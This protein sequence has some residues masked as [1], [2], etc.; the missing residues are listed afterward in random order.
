MKKLML[1]CGSK[2]AERSQVEEARTPDGTSTWTPISH[3]KL[4][5]EIEGSLEKYG[6]RVDSEAYG[7]SEG[8][9]RMFGILSISNCQKTKDYSY[10]LGVR[11][12]HD[13]RF[14]AG[15]CIGSQVFVCDNLAFSSEITINRKHTKH[16][17]R[18]LPDMVFKAVGRLSDR[19]NDQDSRIE[20]YK[21]KRITSVRANDFIIRAH[22]AK[23]C[24]GA[25]ITKIVK[26]YENPRHPEFKPRNA[27]SLFNAFTEVGKENSVWKMA[28][29]T[30]RLHGV[31]DA[32]CD[33]NL[34]GEAIR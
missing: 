30:Q 23:A 24:T 5:G 16:I 11:N 6:M 26:E 9:E 20:A 7:L 25:Q 14:P 15:L 33:L 28:D 18:D 2:L 1:H 34:A 12:S 22:Q 4:L 3:S 32:F 29:R 13:K 17:M 27:W 10:V 31:M 19:W 8:G 21:D